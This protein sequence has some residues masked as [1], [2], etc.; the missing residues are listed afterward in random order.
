[1]LR[2]RRLTVGAILLA[3]AI[4]LA[5]AVGLAPTG[6]SGPATGDVPPPAVRASINALGV[7]VGTPT[8]WTS[9]RTTAGRYVLAFDH[10]VDLHVTSW[11]QLAEVIL[12]PLTAS[13]WQIDFVEEH[14]AVD[15]AFSFTASRAP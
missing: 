5:W 6:A 10:A 13:R 2:R 7:P 11:D 14:R 4:G 12:R 3:I 15:T 9:Q 8:A 1:L